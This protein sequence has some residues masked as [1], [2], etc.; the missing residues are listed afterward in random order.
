MPLRVIEVSASEPAAVT[1]RATAVQHGALE[2]A[3]FASVPDADPGVEAE[4]PSHLVRILVESAGQQRLLD[5]LQGCLAGYTGWRIVLLPVEGAIPLPGSEADKGRGTKEGAGA[6]NSG[7]RTRRGRNAASREELYAEVYRGARLDLT[8]F[9]FVALSTV[10]AAIGMREDNVAVVIGAMVIAPLL[11]P[12]LALSLGVALG[13]RELIVRALQAG[14]LGLLVALLLAIGAGALMPDALASAELRARADVGFDSM[15]LALAS[16]AAA[17]LSLTTGLSSALVGV[18][19]AVALLPPTAA[20]GMF[21]GAG[22]LRHAMGALLLLAVNVVC[23]NLAAQL[24]LWAEGIS[25]RTWHEQKGARHAG[26]ISFLV[27]TVLLIVLGILIL[28][29]RKTGQGP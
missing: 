26:R 9:V 8:Y 27:W 6:A 12:N 29:A 16:G 24:V 25:P 28:L 18:M 2:V 3:E 15:A 20:A 1:V 11:G 22:D 23:V 7:G 5:A 21:I 13:D 10:V 4:H 17:V 19:V 14:G